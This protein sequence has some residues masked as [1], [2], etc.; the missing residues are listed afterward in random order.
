MNNRKCANCGAQ[1]QENKPKKTKYCSD[2][3]RCSANRWRYSA[4]AKEWRKE[5]KRK[6]RREAGVISREEAR[7]LR[8]LID[9]AKIKARKRH[10]YG[11]ED[12]CGPPMPHFVL[13]DAAY[14][15][16]RYN[17]DHVFRNKEIERTRNRKNEM[18]EWYLSYLL[19]IRR[20]E[21]TNEL[22][23]LKREQLTLKRLSKNLKLE[24]KNE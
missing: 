3:C 18:S 4:K 22:L 13:S 24:L 7:Q 23:Q 16:W 1:I 10:R 21:C 15:Y 11:D 2:K 5:Y 19:K 9:Q 8:A 20:N 17:N 6:K 12:F 14:Y